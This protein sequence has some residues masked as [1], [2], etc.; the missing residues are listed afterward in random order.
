MRS[1]THTH[2]TLDIKQQVEIR[3]ALVVFRMNQSSGD[4]QKFI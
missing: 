4:V 1:H 3:A 2:T